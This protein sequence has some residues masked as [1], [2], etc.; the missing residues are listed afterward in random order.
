MQKLTRNGALASCLPGINFLPT[1]P[2]VSPL[3]LLY[4]PPRK[5][6]PY[7]VQYECMTV[8]L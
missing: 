7:T 3:T 8:T 4:P 1:S 6:Q 2:I 5:I